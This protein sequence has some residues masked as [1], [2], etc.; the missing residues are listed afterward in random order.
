MDM[1]TDAGFLYDEASILG[2]MIKG[3]LCKSV[4]Y[5]FEEKQ[6][7]GCREHSVIWNADSLSVNH[8]S[9]SVS[10]KLHHL[11]CDFSF[12]HI[13]TMDDSNSQSYWHI[14]V[15]VRRTNITTDK[16]RW[17]D[18]LTS[19]HNGATA[20]SN[21]PVNFYRNISNSKLAVTVVP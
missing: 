9:R 20:T 12:K 19:F 10:R 3:T 15:C 6:S 18:S 2:D 5:A 1:P 11:T 8:D 4:L 13:I 21:Y 16:D 7:T 17:Q 14:T